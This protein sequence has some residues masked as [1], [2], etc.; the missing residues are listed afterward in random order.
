MPDAPR[1][2]TQRDEK[3]GR[4]KTSDFEAATTDATYRNHHIL[5]LRRIVEITQRDDTRAVKTQ[6]DTEQGEEVQAQEAEE[7]QA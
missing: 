6:K 1:N 2:E 5:Q 4:S 3:R 7:T